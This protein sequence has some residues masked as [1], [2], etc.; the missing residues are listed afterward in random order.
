MCLILS[1]HLISCAPQRAVIDR[2][3][4]GKII[5]PG[6]PEQPR[7]QYLW[8]VSVVAEGGSEGILQLFAGVDE[9][10]TDPQSSPRLLRPYGLFV[11][12][13][14]LLYIADP[15][16]FRISI[17][18][19][20]SGAS[21]KILKAG[22][23]D[24]RSPIGIVAHEGRIYVTDSLLKKVFIFDA[25]GS[26]IGEFE[27]P[28]ER[29]TGIAFNREKGVFYVSD[30]LA[31]TIYLYS[32]NGNRKGSLGKNGSQQ[33][34]FN[35]PTHISVDRKGRLYVM[36]SMNFRVQMFSPDGE[37][38]N[39]FGTLGAGYGDLE[40]PKGVATDSDGNIY[41]VDSIQDTVKIFNREGKLLL[42]FG[43]QGRSYGEFWLPSGIF[44][45]SEDK[46]H[47]AD[48]YNGRV[49]AFQ[50]LGTGKEK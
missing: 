9:D 24:F 34:E 32:R 14:G 18:D 39:M 30:T 41:V 47:I 6:P 49:Q 29:P 8:N 27:G 5:W 37:F 43:R 25:D 16:A 36:D 4:M 3:A 45:D 11:D 33:G 38:E 23:D 35:Y 17:L 12:E 44:I 26:L 40:K 2:T 42:F 28:F 48:T 13:A 19:L 46:I 15:G 21:K 22:N 7:I 1:A 50:Y 20:N 10:L 31:H